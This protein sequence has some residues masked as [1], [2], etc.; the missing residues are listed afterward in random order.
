M[1]TAAVPSCNALSANH[2]PSLLARRPSS[3]AGTVGMLLVAALY[4]SYALLLRFRGS[5]LGTV[6]LLLLILPGVLAAHLASR[7]DPFREGAITGALI[8]AFAA[9][10]QVLILIISVFTTD[11]ASYAALVGPGI[12]SGVQ[13]AAIPAAIIASI[14]II[15]V[16]LIGCVLACWLGAVIYVATCAILSRIRGY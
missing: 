2:R 10:L 1:T 6:W 13:D 16:T 4:I 7:S 14:A 8:A 9:P 12:A 3:V 11:W 5:G 15:V